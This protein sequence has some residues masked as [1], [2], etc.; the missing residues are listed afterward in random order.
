MPAPPRQIRGRR[1][2]RVACR[3][4]R[5]VEFRRAFRG[6]LQIVELATEICRLREHVR[7][8]G[9]V[10][11]LQTLEHRQAILDVLQ[12]RRRRIDIRR[13]RSKE[14]CE[15]LEL[16]FHD[17]ASIEIWRERR[18]QRRQ[19]GYLLPDGPERRQ[20]GFVTFIQCGVRIRT[21]ALQ[22]IGVGEHLAGR[23]QFF[24][25]PRLRRCTIDL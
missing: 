22:A 23:R 13:I 10:L 5:D 18:V 21:Q 19:F 3:R 2:V 20:R 12:P 24:I 11:S 25:F 15:I 1:Q 16:R 9:S 4:Q 6:V 17:L 14:K 8:R 7:Q